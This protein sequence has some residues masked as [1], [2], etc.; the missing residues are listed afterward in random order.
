MVNCSFVNCSASYGGAV[1]FSYDG[2]VVGCSFVG[3]SARY[4]I[5]AIYFGDNA[6]VSVMDFC[7]IYG[8]GACLW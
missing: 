3:C 6:F 1:Y 2:S 7:G 8:A 5:G 4:G